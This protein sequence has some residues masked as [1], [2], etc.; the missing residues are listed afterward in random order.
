MF[1]TKKKLERLIQE[2]RDKVSAE[3]NAN[4]RRNELEDKLDRLESDN[5]YLK[6][7]IGTLRRRVN[8]LDHEDDKENIKLG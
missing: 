5:R 2:E 8:K 3:I 1:I 4:I 6:Y 7:Q